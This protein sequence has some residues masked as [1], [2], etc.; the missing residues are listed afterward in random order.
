MHQLSE[1]GRDQCLEGFD[2]NTW[3]KTCCPVCGS[4][5]TLSLLEGDPVLRFSLCSH[6]GCQWSV[7]RMACSACGNKGP[8]TRSYFYD[9]GAAFYDEGAA[10]NRI[11]LCDSCHHY[12]KTID[13]RPLGSTDPYLEDIA[14]LHLDS[15]AVQK[16]YSRAVPNSWNT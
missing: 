8:D 2:P 13:M 12:I 3:R 1:L 5:P 4:L 7:D 9:E 15:V 14:T 6:C 16:G 10:A 11:D